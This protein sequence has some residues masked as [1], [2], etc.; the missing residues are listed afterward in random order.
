KLRRTIMNVI[1]EFL[2]DE[3]KMMSV[4]HEYA[5][6]NYRDQ[7]DGATAHELLDY[8]NKGLQDAYEKF[9][10]I[11]EELNAIDE[12]AA[13][14]TT[15]QAKLNAILVV[16]ATATRKHGSQNTE[17]TEKVLA[18]FAT[19]IGARKRLDEENLPTL[20][21]EKTIHLS[22]SV[23]RSPNIRRKPKAEI[24]VKEPDDPISLFR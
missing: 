11:K 19:Y 21:S 4:G 15:L 16:Q 8:E 10:H 24:L 22:D 5:R 1:E 17:R 9:Y 23:L 7:M 6:D 20:L 13:S 18:D 3:G 2:N 14:I 12:I